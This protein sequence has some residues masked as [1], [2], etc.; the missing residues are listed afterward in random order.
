MATKI[1]F[2]SGASVVTALAPNEVEN[3]L[4]V[5]IGGGTG[6]ARLPN[7]TEIPV[8]EWYVRADSVTHFHDAET[9]TSADLES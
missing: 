1:H 9:R 7:P 3:A 2:R 6:Y 8:S 5:A 4:V